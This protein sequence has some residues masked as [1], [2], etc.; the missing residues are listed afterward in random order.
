MT[1]IYQ[2]L[3][4]FNCVPQK[5]SSGLFKNIKYKICLQIIYLIYMYKQDLVLSN[6]QKLICHKTQLNQP[7]QMSYSVSKKLWDLL[8]KARIKVFEF[9]KT[10]QEIPNSC[11]I[12]I[13]YKRIEPRPIIGFSLGLYFNERVAMDIKEMDGNKVLHLINHSTRLCQSQGS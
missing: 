8:R 3:K 4:S 7:N 5:I 12:C 9:I 2:Y 6:L 1:V 10:L 11:K 13:R